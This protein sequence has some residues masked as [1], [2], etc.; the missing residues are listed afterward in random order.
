MVVFFSHKPFSLRP[1]QFLILLLALGLAVFMSS[2]GRIFLGP[3]QLVRLGIL[4]CFAVLAVVS[5]VGSI[6]LTITRGPFGWPAGLLLRLLAGTFFGRR[7]VVQNACLWMR[8]STHALI[9]RICTF[10]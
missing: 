1:L 8:T 4:Q 6:F 10:R 5:S 3:V 9:P 2:F 7:V